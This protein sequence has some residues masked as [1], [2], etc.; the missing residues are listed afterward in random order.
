MTRFY[1]EKPEMAW[2]DINKLT[3]DDTYQ[4]D[5][6][7]K[8]SKANIK[9]IMENFSWEKFTPITVVKLS[10]GD[11]N[12]IDGQHRYTAAKN[13]S[14]IE[15]LPCYIIQKQTIKDQSEAFIGINKNRVYTSPYDL[16][17]AQLAAGNKTAV[18]IDDFCNQVG[19]II[20]FNGYCSSPCMTLALNT[21][22]IHLKAHNNSY[23][24]EAIHAIL[25]AF[26]EKNGQLK[27]DI[28]KTLVNLKIE[29]GQKFSTQDIV[30]ALL[31]F[32]NVDQISAKA[33]ELRA[34]DNSLSIPKAH[35]KV[36]ISKLKE[37][38]RK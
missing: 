10:S 12:I 17:K 32:G 38:K 30:N 20:P 18:M 2:I 6:R 15:E 3:V 1:G 16:Y 23:L 4:R 11:Y 19:I 7:G 21:I 8:R 35:L 14:D 24:T 31:S 37:V 9:H 25:A 28:I 5:I 13:L 29:Y 26:P 27:A 36:F 34:L 22:K 33:R